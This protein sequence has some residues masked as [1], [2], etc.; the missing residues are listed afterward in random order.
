MA[1]ITDITDLN[2]PRTNNSKDDMDGYI[3]DLC[4]VARQSRRMKT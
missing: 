2:D 3:Y 4:D 1:Q